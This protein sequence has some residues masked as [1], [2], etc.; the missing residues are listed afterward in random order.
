MLDTLQRCLRLSTPA[1]PE[2]TAGLLAVLWLSA[3]VD[4]AGHT[5][6]RLAWPQVL[7]LHPA[8]QLVVASKRRITRP[9]L[10]AVVDAAERAWTWEVWHK[11]AC[12][13]RGP[14]SDTCPPALAAWMDPGMYARS[15][16]GQLP[17]PATILPR[18][19]AVMTPGAGRHIAERLRRNALDAPAGAV[20]TG[21]NRDAHACAS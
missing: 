15:V 10:T 2:G 14:L 7:E 6:S 4:A 18:A 20:R 21:T 13:G 11:L 17:R 3:V 16:L 12:Q 5:S 8:A 19:M 9:E 1:A